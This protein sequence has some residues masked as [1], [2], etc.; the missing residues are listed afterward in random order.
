VDTGQVYRANHKNGGKGA[1]KQA[2][3]RRGFAAEKRRKTPFAPF[4]H[5]LFDNLI[6][7]FLPQNYSSLRAIL[8]A[9]N[10]LYIAPIHT[11]HL[12]IQ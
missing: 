10:L 1:G 12:Q 11:P 4:L 6:E 5:W 3:K 7:F 8:G 2:F 9:G